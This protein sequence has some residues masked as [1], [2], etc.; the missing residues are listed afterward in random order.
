M[1]QERLRAQSRDLAWI[2]VALTRVDR[3]QT[4]APSELPT[5]ELGH[6]VAR[7]AVALDRLADEPDASDAA[8]DAQRVLIG[9]RLS[10]DALSVFLFGD[11]VLDCFAA[12]ELA[13]RD[14]ALGRAWTDLVKLLDGFPHDPMTP[15]VRYLNVALSFSRDLLAEHFGADHY[16]TVSYGGVGSVTLGRIAKPDEGGEPY[17][18]AV[19][20]LR[21]ALGLPLGPASDPTGDYRSLAD[22]AIEISPDLDFRRAGLVRRAFQLAG[23]HSVPVPWVVDWVVV[24]LR[25]HLVLRSI[26]M[27]DRPGQQRPGS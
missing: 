17:T 3:K 7:L 21:E 22:R 8:D 25:E 15:G 5:H 16:P 27:P 12:V 19:R 6:A 10:F 2:A 20:L 23:S 26:S 11:Q 14:P 9:E 1:Y 24:V 18:S 4:G 13:R